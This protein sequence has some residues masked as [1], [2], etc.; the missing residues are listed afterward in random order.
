MQKIHQT[1]TTMLEALAAITVVS[2]LLIGAIKLVG[3]MFDMFKQN[4]IVSEIQEIQKNI[5][6]RYRLEGNFSGLG[7]LTA[8]QIHEQKLVPSQML[9]N[10]SLVHR[11]N[12]EVKIDVS[13]L[14]NEFFD[15]EFNGLTNRTCV[16]LS[17]INWN[18]SLSTDLYQIKIND[19]VYKLPIPAN[20]IS[21]GDE[22]ALPITVTKAVSSCVDDDNTIVWTFQ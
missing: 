6:S 16:N 10:G 18:N 9:V 8:T 3:K 7:G 12:G 4:M 5:N 1:G 19:N 20:G 15:V 11:M 13:A 21:F 14:G 22:A 2:V 17:Q